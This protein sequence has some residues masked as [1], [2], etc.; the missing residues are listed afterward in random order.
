MKRAFGILLTL[1]LCW[2]V[3]G[4]TPFSGQLTDSRRTAIRSAENWKK[5][6]FNF[7]PNTMTCSD[8]SD[9]VQAIRRAA[10]WDEKGYSIDPNGKTWQDVDEQAHA[11]DRARFWNEQGYAFDPNAMT[12]AE[13]DGKAKE[14]QEADFWAKAGCYYDPNTQAVYV[15]KGSTTKLGSLPLPGKG[16][17][18]SHKGGDSS[19]P[20]ISRGSGSADLSKGA[21][22]RRGSMSG[23]AF[24]AS[25]G[26]GHCVKKRIGSGRFVLLE[27]HSLWGISPVDS[28]NSRVWFSSEQIVVTNNANPRYPYRLIN[29]DTS[30][31]AQARLIAKTG[32]H[33]ISENIDSGQFLLLEDDSLWEVNPL[34]TLNSALW[35]SLSDIVITDSDNGAWPNLLINT[36]DGEDVEA[37]R[38]K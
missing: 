7:D 36:D 5:Q 35:L 24:Y 14:L 20:V 11:I 26:S 9:R 13:M 12:I 31:T 30:D 1:T 19:L 23:S 21:A 28:T 29:T 10:Y 3:S 33:W 25:T 38:L 34:D 32:T 16:T 15:S 2:I 8:M 17:Y 37:K 18:A 22:T 27:D 6:G 4:C